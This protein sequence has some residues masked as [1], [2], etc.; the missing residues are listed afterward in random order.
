MPFYLSVV[1]DTYDIIHNLLIRFFP[2]QICLCI[3]CAESGQRHDVCQ[4]PVL[5]QRIFVCRDISV[6]IE[7]L[8]LRN[9]RPDTARPVRLVLIMICLV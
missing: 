4:P 8:I 7:R 9:I 5:I 3:V 2:S 1:M 6:C